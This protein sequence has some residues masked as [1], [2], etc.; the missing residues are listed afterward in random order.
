MSDGISVVVGLIASFITKCFC[1]KI[2]VEPQKRKKHIVGFFTAIP[3]LLE[4]P[5]VIRVN[6]ITFLLDNLPLKW[7]YGYILAIALLAPLLAIL[8]RRK[9]KDA[10]DWKYILG[11]FLFNLLGAVAALAMLFT[12]KKEIGDF[13]YLEEFYIQEIIVLAVPACL[14]IALS[15][16]AL[17]QEKHA[18]NANDVNNANKKM[19]HSPS[20]EWINQVFNVLHLFN[21]YFFSAMSSILIVSYTIYC[22]SHHMDLYLNIYYLVFLSSVLVFFYACGL[23]WSE[24]VHMVFLV[25]VPVILIS[26][27]Y[28][29]SWFVVDRDMMYWHLAYIIIHS[30]A[31]VLILYVK[32]RVIVIGWA[33]KEKDPAYQI[34][35]NWKISVEIRHMFYVVMVVTIIVA[36][37]VLGIVPFQIERIPYNRTVKYI[38]AI[39]RDTDK[40]ADELLEEMKSR[41]WWDDENADADRTRYLK[42]LYDNLREEMIEKNVISGEE[43]ALSYDD[44]ITWFDDLPW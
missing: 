44:L 5:K 40:N 31:Y 42:F 2:N 1:D 13:R 21:A 41:E 19:D 43:K 8:D 27:T 23:H 4:L 33:E 18:K 10:A 20:L 9:S 34:H 3:T 16:Q 17:E 6:S 22:H 25:F 7:I 38:N 36:Y 37:C 30:L 29:M 26:S 32:N 11:N 28:W 35:F 15:Y 12:A 39:C 14:A 24:H